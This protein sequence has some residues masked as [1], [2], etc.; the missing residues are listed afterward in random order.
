MRVL[1]EYEVLGDEIYSY[2]ETFEYD[3]HEKLSG[4]LATSYT[5][6]RVSNELLQRGVLCNK[7]EVLCWK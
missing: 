1:V 3:W 5:K 6:K 4:K 2:I 7:I